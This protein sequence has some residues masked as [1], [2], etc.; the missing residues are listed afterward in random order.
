MASWGKCDF[1]QLK[2][3][4]KRIEKV[5]KKD[6]RKFC[7]ECAKELAVRL[8]AKVIRKTPV[9][10]YDSGSGKTGGTL[11]RGWTAKTESEAV[12]GGNNANAKAYASSLKITKTG[13]AYQIEIINPVNYAS[14][15]EYGHRTRNH[16]GWVPGRF[17]LTVSEKELDTQAPKVLERKLIKY[18]GEC[19]DGK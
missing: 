9:G 8:L 12:S 18:L 15:V 1:R 17:M 3:L 10:Q 5:Q 14:Y 4:Q 2:N 6:Y 16:K 11:R 19:F 7:E 13:N